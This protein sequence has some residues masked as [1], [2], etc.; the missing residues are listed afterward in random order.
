M[1]VGIREIKGQLSHY[2]RQVKQGET[3]IITER[4]VPVA[5]LVSY[6]MPQINDI[7]VL[8]K[9][10]IVTWSGGKPKGLTDSPEIRINKLVS[11]MIAEDRR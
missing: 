4:N 7:A 9:A 5:K 8:Q 3:I 6:D 2:I 10:G 11:D 1:N